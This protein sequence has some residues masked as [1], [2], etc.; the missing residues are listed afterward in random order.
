MNTLFNPVAM[1]GV[2]PGRRKRNRLNYCF[3]SS[4]EINETLKHCAGLRGHC[5]HLIG[6]SI[7]P[8]WKPVCVFYPSFAEH[9]D[10]LITCQHPAYLTTACSVGLTHERPFWKL[11]TD[12]NRRT[13]AMTLKLRVL[14]SLRKH[15]PRQLKKNN[16]NF[17]LHFCLFFQH[18]LKLKIRP[19]ASYFLQ[20]ILNGVCSERKQD[21]T[22]AV[23]LPL[24][25][26]CHI[27][28]FNYSYFSTSHPV[29]VVTLMLT[30][31][32]CS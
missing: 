12:P 11:N 15:S 13:A 6:Y 7:I 23:S 17:S 28:I 22:L 31:C 16:N 26:F 14:S 25:W 32:V 4:W 21:F 9:S 10:M 18:F 1:N 3:K 24:F 8:S 29:G 5:P 20:S 30:Q 19:T 27:Y 2:H